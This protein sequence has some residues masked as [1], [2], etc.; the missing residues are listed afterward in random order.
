VDAVFVTIP[1]LI[2]L[3]IHLRRRP[4]LLLHAAAVGVVASLGIGATLVYN[5]QLTGNPLEMPV[6]QY[7]NERNP[8]EQFGLGF[9]PQMGTKLHGD[10]WPGFT[11][12]DAVKVTAYRMVEFLKDLYGLPVILLAAILAGL[13]GNWRKWGEWRLVLLASAGAVIVVYFFHFYHGIAYGSRHYFLAVPATAMV[14]G[15]LVS[16]ALGGG[17]P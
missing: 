4:R 16:R 14:V 3:L 8:Q 11:P 2:Q 9:G 17:S 10:E 15:G 1:F 12:V 7:F 5:Q 6:T 13:R